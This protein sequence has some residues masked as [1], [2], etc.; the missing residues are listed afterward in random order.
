MRLRAP[1]ACLRSERRLECG[2]RSGTCHGHPSPS[3]TPCK[4]SAIK[5]SPRR[6]R[7]SGYSTGPG[8]VHR[9]ARGHARVWARARAR[10]VGV[11]LHA[12]VVASPTAT[13]SG[14][15][16]AV[17]IPHDLSPALTDVRRFSWSEAR[18]SVRLASSVSPR[19]TRDPPP[20]QPSACSISPS[21]AWRCCFYY[22][23]LRS[24]PWRY[25][26]IR[27]AQSF[28]ANAA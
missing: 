25:C 9:H 6:E 17:T 10:V 2:S 11:P 22:R 8:V 14:C 21:R 26:S 23:S 16:Q 24:S 12:Y 18:R 20:E 19:S 13:R 15:P 7:W 5:Q 4:A 28:F 3:L 27:G 1:V